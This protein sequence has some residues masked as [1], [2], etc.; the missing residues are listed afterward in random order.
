M[1]P[2]VRMTFE[3]FNNWKQHRCQPGWSESGGECSGGKGQWARIKWYK[4]LSM[5]LQPIQLFLGG[6]A[7][8]HL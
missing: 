6:L 8:Y 5:C 1:D 2:I 4:S 3:I 7:E